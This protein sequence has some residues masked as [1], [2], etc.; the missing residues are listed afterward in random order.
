MV[1]AYNAEEY[2]NQKFEKGNI[3][4]MKTQLFNQRAFALLMPSV[5]L[6]MNALSLVIYWVGAALV[7]NVPAADTSLRLRWV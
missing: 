5:T 1:H 3:D 6:A 4:L 2:Q 7:N